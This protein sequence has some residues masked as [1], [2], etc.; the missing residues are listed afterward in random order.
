MK[1][2]VVILTDALL[3]RVLPGASDVHAMDLLHDLDRIEA[4]LGDRALDH[5]KFERFAEDT[6]SKLYPG[7]SPDPRGNG[8]G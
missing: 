7:L 6:L 4:L 5:R 8:L 3:F 1:S 2:G